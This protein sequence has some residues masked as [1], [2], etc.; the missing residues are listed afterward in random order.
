M[1]DD[2]QAKLKELYNDLSEDVKLMMAAAINAEREN[3]H[4]SAEGAATTV[5]EQLLRK[6]ETLR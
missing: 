2:E 4:L 5:V 3:L 1:S 6:A